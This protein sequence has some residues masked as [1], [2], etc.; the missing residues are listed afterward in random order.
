M[1]VSNASILNVGVR[2]GYNILNSLSELL[3]PTASQAMEIATA[4]LPL[5]QSI[6]RYFNLIFQLFIVIGIIRLI[7]K[8]NEMKFNNEFKAFSFSSF[9]ITI[10]GVALPYFASALNSDRLLHLNL[11]FLAPYCIIGTLTFIDFLARSLKNIKFN[12]SIVR[13]LTLNLTVLLLILYFLLNS[14]FLY[15]VFDQP[16]L[17]RF[18]LD[19]DIDFMYFNDKE[20]SAAKWLNDVHTS[21]LKIYADVNRAGPLHSI[22]DEVN[23]MESWEIDK[24]VFFQ[25]SYIFLGKFNIEH[26]QLFVRQAWNKVAYIHSP[27]FVWASNKIYDNG[28]SLIFISRR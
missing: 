16:K 7:L 17:G 8:H 15:Q 28:G 25:N 4:K 21:K 12:K 19:K 22:I 13:P 20:L 18:A 5:L 9:G 3:S 23:E 2:I 27:P 26:Q 11:F 24:K 6:E 10:A 14:A 1:Y